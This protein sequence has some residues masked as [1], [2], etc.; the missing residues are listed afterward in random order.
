MTGDWDV[1]KIPGGTGDWGGSYLAIPKAS[2]HQKEADDL[3]SWLT[4]PDQQKT[5]FTSQ[6]HFPSSQTAAQDP[7]IASHTDQYFG[8]LAAGPDLLRLGGHDPAGGPRRQGRDDQGH[9]LQGDHPRGG[10]GPGPGASWSKALSDI[11]SA[12]SG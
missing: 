11:K 7:A 1:A 6:G 9:V 5:M 2:K 8:D 3:I 4:A 12:T 10:P